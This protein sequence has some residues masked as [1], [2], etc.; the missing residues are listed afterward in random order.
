MN[1]ARYSRVVGC[2]EKAVH[3]SHGRIERVSADAAG[4]CKMNECVVSRK[5]RSRGGISIVRVN[6]AEARVLERRRPQRDACD[7]IDPGSA[8]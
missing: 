2:V 4:L 6:R 5:R 3:R 7:G 1:E 8:A